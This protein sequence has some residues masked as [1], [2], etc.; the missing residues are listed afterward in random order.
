MRSH[1]SRWPRRASELQ[2]SGGGSRNIAAAAVL[3]FKR[4]RS[5]AAV[6][7]DAAEGWFSARDGWLE[8]R[9]VEALGPGQVEVAIEA[10]EI[11]GSDLHY[12]NHGGFGTPHV[13]IC[14]LKGF[15]PDRL[16]DPRFSISAGLSNVAHDITWT[17][18]LMCDAR[19]V[20]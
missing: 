1:H 20:P 7:C 17:I 3:K 11:C 19:Q 4:H 16:Q 15:P 5:V 8:E 2:E 13:P 9:K 12:Y 18:L 6:H 14:P 10:G